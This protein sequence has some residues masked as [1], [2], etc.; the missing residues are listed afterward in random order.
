MYKI[1]LFVAVNSK[2]LLN[3]SKA[4]K[5][6]NIPIFATYVLRMSAATGDIKGTDTSV[7]TANLSS[8]SFHKAPS[9]IR[10]HQNRVN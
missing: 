4:K 6:S 7:L 9:L 10:S 2:C 8:P 1:N 5:S 3:H